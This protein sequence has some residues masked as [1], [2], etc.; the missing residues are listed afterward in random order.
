[1][2]QYKRRNTI[3][4]GFLLAMTGLAFI[5][6]TITPGIDLILL[7]L[8]A[9]A[10]IT[11]FALD[12]GQ[13]RNLINQ[14]SQRAS[15]S[16]RTSKLSPTAKEA[17]NR[18]QG[19]G[20]M[21]NPYLT[22]IDVGLIAS[23]VGED[24]MSMRRTRKITKDQNGV[25]PFVTFQVEAQE[26]DRK[27]IVRFE[28][29]DQQGKS[30]YIHEQEVYLRDGE[31]N[32]LADHHLPLSGN[33]RINGMGDWDLRVQIDGQLVGIHSFTL[34]PSYEE[35]QQR[36]SGRSKQHYVT[37]SDSDGELSDDRERN[38]ERV[39]LEDLLGEQNTNNNHR[40]RR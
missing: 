23:M 17:V 22:M 21:T 29:I 16:L 38:S 39:T 34:S 25:R 12:A 13:P 1:M 18:A 26:A 32:I 28:L 15:Q 24:G 7:A 20:V 3:W 27:A 2:F 4:L 37:Q 19:R 8:I 31:F 6:G 11:S 10:L 5:A 36:L 33:D 40:Q 35:R 9:G 14:L 30:Q